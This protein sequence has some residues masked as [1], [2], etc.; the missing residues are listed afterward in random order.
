MQALERSE[1]RHACHTAS[2]GTCGGPG[3][4]NPPPGAAAGPRCRQRTTMPSWPPQVDD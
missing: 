2:G 1:P 3:T 4:A